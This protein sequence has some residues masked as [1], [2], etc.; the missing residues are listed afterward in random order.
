MGDKIYYLSGLGDETFNK[1]CFSIENIQN[2]YEILEKNFKNTAY[3]KLKSFKT[4]EIKEIEI[5]P[6]FWQDLIDD[7]KLENINLFNRIILMLFWLLDFP[8]LFKCLNSK[9]KMVYINLLIN[10][11]FLISWYL[12][13]F[14]VGGKFIFD[15]SEINEIKNLLPMINSF[16][17]N[18][19]LKPITTI[20]ESK[21]IKEVLILNFLV[22][23]KFKNIFMKALNL[24]FKATTFIKFREKQ[25]LINSRIISSIEKNQEIKIVC[26]SFAGVV[27]L[28][29]IINFFPNRFDS[30]KFITLG[31][32]LEFFSY[33]SLK[34]KEDLNKLKYLLEKES[35]NTQWL[36]V[37]NPSDWYSP[38]LPSILKDLN[39]NNFKYLKLSKEYNLFECFKGKPHFEYFYDTNTILSI[40]EF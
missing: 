34:I 22:Y 9:N 2:E 14:I 21:T 11:V 40:L 12:S 35:V 31:S 28:N 16:I 6:I 37:Y 8:F 20:L 4:N 10:F 25:A 39:S 23:M 1:F 17:N 7:N 26:H 3:Y 19:I 36:F 29:S 13:F 24:I 27:C 32:S 15:G 18:Y 38:D 30:I 33:K 5:V